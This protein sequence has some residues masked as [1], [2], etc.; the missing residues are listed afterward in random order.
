M[1]QAVILKWVRPDK[2]SLKLI[3]ESGLKMAAAYATGAPPVFTSDYFCS[4]S[5]YTHQIQKLWVELHYNHYLHFHKYRT[6][7]ILNME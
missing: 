6:W 7:L 1:I 3:T 4:M 2:V 5:S